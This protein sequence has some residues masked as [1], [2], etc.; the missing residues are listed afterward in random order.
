MTK[1]KPKKHADEMDDREAIRAV[2]P[3]K[4]VEVLEAA[5]ID[6]NSTEEQDA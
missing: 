5:S 3:P 6:E 2:F 4:V 1:K